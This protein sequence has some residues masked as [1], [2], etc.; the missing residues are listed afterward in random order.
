MPKSLITLK[1]EAIKAC[2]ANKHIMDEFEN[3]RQR[4][5]ATAT[6]LCC[7]A[8]IRVN[9]EPLPKGFVQ[10]SGSALNTICT[11]EIPLNRIQRST[12]NLEGASHNGFRARSLSNLSL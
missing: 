4:T 8:W 9:T 3:N 11:R 10:L 12:K 7:P 5:R 2:R 6:C 1:R